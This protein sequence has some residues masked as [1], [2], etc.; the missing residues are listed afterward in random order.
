MDTDDDEYCEQYRGDCYVRFVPR[1]CALNDLRGSWYFTRK[2]VFLTE[3]MF[4]LH[5]NNLG[6]RF[7]RYVINGLIGLAAF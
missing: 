3:R 7:G 5:V 2:L 6:M 1:L 4:S